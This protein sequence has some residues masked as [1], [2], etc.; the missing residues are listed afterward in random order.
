MGSILGTAAGYGFPVR[1]GR[2]PTDDAPEVMFSL[3]TGSALSDGLT[4]R[5]ATGAPREA[6]PDV[7]AAARQDGG[8][9]A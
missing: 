3:V 6:F 2:T 7:A 8:R 5:H 1:N 4:G 9:G